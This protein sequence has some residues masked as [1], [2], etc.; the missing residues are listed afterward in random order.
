MTKKEI[1]QAA[2]ANA[3]NYC[4]QRGIAKAAFV[5]GALWA[6]KKSREIMEKAKNDLDTECHEESM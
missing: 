4:M 6:M 5:E 3:M 2:E 1:L